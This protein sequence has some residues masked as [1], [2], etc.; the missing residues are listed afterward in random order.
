MFALG[1]KRV[2]QT[3]LSPEDAA[4]ALQR[5]ILP[6]AL[7]ALDR[8]RPGTPALRGTVTG[9]SF[10]VVRRTQFRNSFTPIVEGAIVPSEVGSQVQLTLGMHF[11]P[12]LTMVMWLAAM[13][14]L[15]VLAAD[16]ELLGDMALMLVGVALAGPLLA[17]AF[18]RADIEAVV[19]EISL[20]VTTP[21]T[22]PVASDAAT[23]PPG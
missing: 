8:P 22:P 4:A 9:T 3:G 5:A 2:V 6:G 12:F 1:P 16:L 15:G 18:Y 13:L 7:F 14:T 23:A 11:I 10:T 20:A 19:A 21:V 17:W